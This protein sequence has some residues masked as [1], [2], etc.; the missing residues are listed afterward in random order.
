M[1]AT[2]ILS[3]RVARKSLFTRSSASLPL[4][5]RVV[6][7]LLPRVRPLSPSWRMSLSTRLP[8]QRTPSALNS[9]WTLGDP[10]VLRPRWWISRIVSVRAPSSRSLAEEGLSLQP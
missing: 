4:P 8:E 6:P 2:H 1:S 9:A 5:R 10:H 7:P 3:F